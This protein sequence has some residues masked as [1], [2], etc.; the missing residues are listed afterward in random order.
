MGREE[1]IINERKRKL[2]ELC[3]AGINP[4]P[5][6]FVQKNFSKEIK[7][8][9]KKLKNNQRRKSK[10]KVAGRVMTK[11]DLGKLIFLIIQDS[12]GRLQL[13][14]EKGNSAFD[15]IKKY[16]SEKYKVDI[17]NKIILLTVGR[18]IKRKGVYWFVNKVLSKLP[19]R[20]I[21]IVVGDGPERKRIEYLIFKRR[22]QD[23]VFLL[24]KITDRDLNYAYH[25]ADIFVMPNI[26]V[27]G[28]YE[29]FGMVAVEASCCS[30]PIVASA[31]EGIMD[32]VKEGVNGLLVQPR[33]SEEFIDKLNYIIKRKEARNNMGKKGREYVLRNYD[34][35]KVIKEYEKNF[36]EVLNPNFI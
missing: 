8:E 35:R 2:N 21:Y 16:I 23:R 18:L 7:E 4:Y 6:K 28:D 13:I 19:N 24:G 33:D 34:W 11:R 31:C 1:Q 26:K 12:N 25:L 17:G 29:G 10:V 15:F 9:Y 5:H 22:L 32:S 30:L 3:K 27:S 20:V 36:K 14:F